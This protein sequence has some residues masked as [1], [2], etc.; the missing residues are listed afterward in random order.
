[1][2]DCAAG[3]PRVEDILLGTIVAIGFLQALSILANAARA[4]VIA[5]MLGPEG[6]GVVGIIDQVVLVV[7]N[8]SALSLPLAAVTILSRS[9]G[10]GPVAFKH[11][12]V[13]FLTVLS[14]STL[15]GT[16][17]AVGLV[18]T[19]SSLLGESL[20]LYQPLLILGLLSVPGLA[21]STFGA[22]VLAAAQRAW[23][24]AVVAAV[25]AMALFLAAVAG[26]P[27]AGLEGLYWISLA[28]GALVAG[29]VF[30]YLHRQLRLPFFDRKVSL[31]GALARHPD[32][33][34]FCASYFLVSVSYPL[35]WLIARHTVLANFGGAEAGRLQ[36]VIGLMMGFGMVLRPVNSQLLLPIVNGPWDAA[37]KFR[38][39]LGIQRKLTVALALLAMPLVLFPQ[40]V[41]AILYSTAFAAAGPY[42]HLFIG[43]E[44]IL[45]LGGTYQA[46]VLGLNDTR[47][48][49]LEYFVGYGSLGMLSWSLGRDYGI[50]G[51]AASAI[52]ASLLIFGL[53]LWR[54]RSRHGFALPRGL[55]GLMIGVLAAIFAAGT[56]CARYD[57]G[58]AAAMLV[59]VAALLV[60]AA[61]LIC[62]L[63]KEDRSWVYGFLIRSQPKSS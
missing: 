19:R 11:T 37:R 33:V 61:S 34:F 51:V 52:T 18:A 27:L 10:D 53:A 38:D 4:K 56:A 30:Y 25:S 40:W 29:A 1:M 12:Y 28:A 47:A 16:A 20:L 13:T 5:V 46:L 35:A 21:W 26:I 22:S 45:I 3:R 57:D 60:F 6:V 62:G 31:A 9:C 55:L 15:V 23:Q 8:L 43:A 44:V 32:L 58:S 42:V 49:A 41:L 54:L 39:T 63:D 7:M 36:A 24:S 2:W 14:V 50:L 17:G 59:K 48:W